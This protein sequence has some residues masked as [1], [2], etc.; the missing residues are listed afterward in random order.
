MNLLI[1][2]N[3]TF[4]RDYSEFQSFG[5]I[6]CI[7]CKDLSGADFDAL[8][9]EKH[10]VIFTGGPQHIPR[11]DEYPELRHELR[12]LD[13][14]IQRNL[15]IIGICLGFQLINYYFGNTIVE[16]PSLCCGHNFV[17]TTTFN[18]YG[19]PHL[20]KIDVNVFANSFSYHYDGVL[21]NTHPDIRVVAKSV[22]LGE[23]ATVIIYA[24][25]HARLPIYAV[26]NH[27]EADALS[28]V[29]MFG[30]LRKPAE[31]YQTICHNFLDSLLSIKT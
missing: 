11:I 5:R 2:N 21:T 10:A 15:K 18:T 3:S 23:S 24:I 1:V 26:Q 16:L 13:V 25:G 7:Y 29:R 17:D 27:P 28:I 30:V 31:Y 4:R 22:P 20:Q 14:A 19:D 6:E 9:N 12:L 8:L